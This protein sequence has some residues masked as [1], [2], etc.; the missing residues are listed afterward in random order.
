MEFRYRLIVGS[1]V[2][3]ALTTYGLA[4]D[5]PAKKFRPSGDGDLNFGPACMAVEGSS[6]CKGDRLAARSILLAPEEIHS[7]LMKSRPQFTIPN[8]WNPTEFSAE[9]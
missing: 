9:A 4:E 7:E 8:S 5:L 2:F 1:T 6:S 3:Q